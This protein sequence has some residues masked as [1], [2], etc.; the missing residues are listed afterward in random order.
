VHADLPQAHTQPMPRIKSTTARRLLISVLACAIALAAGAI[1]AVATGARLTHTPPAGRTHRPPGRERIQ[2]PSLLGGV[3]PGGGVGLGQ[4][5][6]R[7]NIVFVLTDDLSMNLLRFMP[8]VQ[9]M[10]R[11]GMTFENYFVS[12]SLCCPSRSSI[13]TG[14]FPHDTHVFGN[15]GPGGGF[16]AFYSHGDQRHTFSLALQR[17][18]YRTAM[19]GKYLNGYLSTPGI[20]TDGSRPRAVRPTYVPPGWSEWDVAG[21]GYPEFKY[22]MNQDGAI[23]DYGSGP[24]DYLTDVLADK[25][26]DFIS[27]AASDG[28][29]FFLEL[30]TFAPHSPFVPAPEDAA[31]FPGL[32]APRTPNFDQLPT[33]APSWLRG[34]RPLN[35]VEQARIDTVFRLRAQ[36][37]QSV[38]RMIGRIEAS[39]V[40]AG[41]AGNTYLVFSSDNGLHAGEYRLMPGKLTAFDTDIRVPLVIVGPGVPA[42]ASTGALT[43]NIDLADTFAQI[44]G[45]SVRGDGRSLLP[46]LHGQGA[47]D[48]RNAVLIEHHGPH[49]SV[50]D[51]DFQQPAS[52]SPWTYE[53]MRTQAFLY[54]EYVDGEREFYDLR[55]DP[56]ELHN[57]AFRLTR[58][59]RRQL[60]SELLTMKRCHGAS[61]CWAAMHVAQ[62]PG[63]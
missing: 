21:W 31:D 14:E 17:S 61:A 6:G 42:G 37:V 58:S 10:E 18:G 12:D 11:R 32:K 53:A 7:P 45:T 36:D 63:L 16:H 9:A 25:G 38:D 34:H 46:L 19:M 47:T 54:V 2:P 39:L 30:A 60:H 3:L 44:G 40:A 27:R 57:I 4:S 41:V 22:R 51:P 24:Q 52:G 26:V 1:G 5:A 8:H 23:Q 59:E 15:F 50:L 29:P 35:P 28:Q 33:H 55:S 56:F 20:A 13:F 48:W 49:L 62:L 43:E